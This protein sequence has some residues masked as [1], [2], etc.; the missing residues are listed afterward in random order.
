MTLCT[1]VQARMGSTRLPGKVLMRVG[2]RTILEHCLHRVGMCSDDTGLLVVA[3]GSHARDDVIEQLCTG[4]KVECYRSS[5]VDVLHRYYQAAC[6]FG[7]SM[8]LRV[9][10]DMPLLCP[11]LTALVLE[12]PGD[13][14]YVTVENVPL[15]LACE[16]VTMDALERMHAKAIAPA[17][18]EHVTL[19]ALNHP[20]EFSLVRLRSED[21]LFDRRHWRLTVDTEEDLLLLKTLDTDSGGRVFDMS[22]REIVGLVEGNVAVRALAERAA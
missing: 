3:T 5:E 21:W 18:R 11:E 12:A 17:D 16:L 13:P 1:I 4:L 22:T 6:H 15:G 20:A 14:D 9:T 2:D 8:I 7:A 19:Y 10:A